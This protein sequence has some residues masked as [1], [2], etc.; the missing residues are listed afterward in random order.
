MDQ[1]IDAIRRNKIWELVELPR[2][3]KDID[4]KWVYKT[5]LNLQGEVD[6]YK[7]RLV[8][9][10]YKQKFGMNYKKYLPRLLALKP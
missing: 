1:E 4:V 3:K 7:A 2:G 9:K 8:L 5:K 6:K 10:G